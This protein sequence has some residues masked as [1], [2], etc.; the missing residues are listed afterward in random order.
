VEI[1]N[2]IFLNAMLKKASD[3]HIEPREKKLKIRLRVD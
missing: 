1:V 2:D 3:I